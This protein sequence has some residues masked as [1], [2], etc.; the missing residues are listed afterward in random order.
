MIETNHFG[1]LQG[2]LANLLGDTP[3]IGMSNRFWKVEAKM[4]EGSIEQ[5]RT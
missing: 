2:K 3:A 1:R 5:G 4:V